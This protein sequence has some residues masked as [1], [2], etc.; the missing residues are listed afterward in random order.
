MEAASVVSVGTPDADPL[1]SLAMFRDRDSSHAVTASHHASGRPSASAASAD[2]D[3][4]DGGDGGGGEGGSGGNERESSAGGHLTTARRGKRNSMLGQAG[5]KGGKLVD[6]HTMLAGITV[7]MGRRDA[8]DSFHSVQS[9][10][11]W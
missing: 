10:R 1:E 8:G 4:G 9:V 2:G 3:G 11:S 7:G 6:A 5:G